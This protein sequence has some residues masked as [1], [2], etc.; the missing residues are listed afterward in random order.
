MAATTRVRRAS[1]VW[2]VAGKRART[3]SPALILASSVD[4]IWMRKSIGSTSS[5]LT[6]G[7]AGMTDAY[8]PS[9]T[10]RLTMMPLKGAR[11]VASRRALRPM[12]TAV[13]ACSTPAWAPL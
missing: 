2:P 11:T 12:A 10:M 4:G 13:S 1:T 7:V 6:S 5:M 9:L 3:M 8:S